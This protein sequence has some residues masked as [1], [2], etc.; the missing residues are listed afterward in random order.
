MRGRRRG[1]QEEFRELAPDDDSA[2]V[3]KISGLRRDGTAEPVSP[4]QILRR[5]RRQGRT[6]FG[7]V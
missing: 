7:P 5:E 3:R 4:D 1:K 2:S 6:Y